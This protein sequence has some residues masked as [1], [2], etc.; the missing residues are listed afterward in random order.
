MAAVGY[1]D[2]RPRA[3]NADVDGR[4]AN[5]R[6]EL[7]VLVEPDNATESAIPLVDAP[8]IDAS[9]GLDE[10]AAADITGFDDPIFGS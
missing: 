4:Q 5:R 8:G 2:T 3:S 10:V 1:S 6:T 7:V 9:A